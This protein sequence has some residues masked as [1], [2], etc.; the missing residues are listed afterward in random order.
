MD[1]FDAMRAFVQVVDSGGFAAAGRVLN[2]SR[3]AVNKHVLQLEDRLGAQLL[4]RT[5]RKVAPTDTGYAFYD[6]C[7]AI[8]GDLE[9][10]ELAVSSLQREARGTL[11]VNAPMSFGLR[12]LT[13]AVSEFMRRF[14]QLRIELTLSDQIT[15]P[16]ESGADVTIRVTSPPGPANLTAHKITDGRMAICAAPAYLERRGT[17]R[18]PDELKDHACLHYGNLATGNAWTLTGADGTHT[19]RVSGPLCSNNGEALRDAALAGHGI[20]MQPTFIAG[21]DIEEGRLQAILCDYSP[22]EIA[23]YLAYPPKRHL[24]AKIQLFTEFLKERLAAG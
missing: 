8:L 21:R 16:L 15:D 5:T 3:S 19:V 24:S 6:R 17:P 7:L 13:G 4:T 18:H 1:R 11:A 9:A 23:V 10:A 12:R 14:P 2:M 20:V 22:P